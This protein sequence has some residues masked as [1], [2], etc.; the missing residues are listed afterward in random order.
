MN[1]TITGTKVKKQL[2]KRMTML[3]NTEFEDFSDEIHAELKDI[4]EN[5]RSADE[6]FTTAY[7]IYNYASEHAE[8]P[9]SMPLKGAAWV[10]MV[11]ILDVANNG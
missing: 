4:V 5:W 8:D 10:L 11:T 3:K 7:S 9:M 6:E 1:K 2:S